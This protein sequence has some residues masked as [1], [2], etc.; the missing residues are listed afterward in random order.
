M[1]SHHDD[2]PFL[3]SDSLTPAASQ[4]QNPPHGPWLIARLAL[5]GATLLAFLLYS[6]FTTLLLTAG[7]ADRS[8][9]YAFLGNA[10]LLLAFTIASWIS[11]QA[12]FFFGC[13]TITVQTVITLLLLLSQGANHFRILLINGAILLT[14]LCLTLLARK[15]AREA[16]THPRTPVRDSPN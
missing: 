5:R 16:H 13:S 9:G 8:A 11:L 1:S 10:T 12:T 4:P 3:V 14:L 2:N 15:L 6:G 7:I